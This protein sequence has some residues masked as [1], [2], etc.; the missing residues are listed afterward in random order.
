MTD[1]ILL[2][3]SQ[4]NRL[5]LWYSECHWMVWCHSLCD[6]KL[7]Y[8]YKREK[9]QCNSRWK[10]V[11]N[12]L[13]NYTVYILY[14]MLL[15][16]RKREIEFGSNGQHCSNGY[17]G[18]YLFFLFPIICCFVSGSHG[19]KVWIE[20]AQ[21]RLVPEWI[22]NIQQKLGARSRCIGI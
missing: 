18:C 8:R 5:C 2:F 10:Y 1:M 13:A 7:T 19:I 3:H 15:L 20:S 14:V 9:L 4:L 22:Y 17:F 12:L 11:Y 6:G 21:L 16:G